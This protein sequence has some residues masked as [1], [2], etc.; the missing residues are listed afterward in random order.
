MAAHVGYSPF[1]CSVK[2]R[3]YVGMTY[4]RYLA[5]LRLKSAADDLRYTMDTVTEI[6]LRYGY[7]STESLSRALAAAV[8]CSPR[9]YRRAFFQSEY[10]EDATCPKDQ[11]ETI[12][13]GAI[14]E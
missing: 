1:Y 8:G 3:E 6:A 5:R 13:A 14:V 4:K 12:P 9:E 2:F 11:A 7:G 10:R